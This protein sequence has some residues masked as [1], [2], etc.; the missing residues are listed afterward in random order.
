MNPAGHGKELWV[1]KAEKGDVEPFLKLI[2]LSGQL[3]PLLYGE[4]Y[5]LMLNALFLDHDN[6]YSHEH[7]AVADSQEGVIGML[8]GYDKKAET[9][10][11][12]VTSR[13][14][15]KILGV[16]YYLH[17]L[18]MIRVHHY[19]GTM[20]KDDYIISQI[21]TFPEARG[22]GAGKMLMD[23]A[24]AEARIHGS[25]RIVLDVLQDNITAIDFYKNNGFKTILTRPPL[26]LQKRVF[27]YI[28][29]AR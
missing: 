23:F 9:E 19:I 17:L 6:L 11:S 4:Q 2:S 28:R 14:I 25:Q 29:M 8:H 22:R 16:N 5:S 21:A 20:E 3:L 13:R 24:A 15:R 27:R 12:L 26:T 1:R 10:K 18:D 7:A